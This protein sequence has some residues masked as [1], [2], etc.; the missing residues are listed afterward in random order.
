MSS[1]AF[2]FLDASCEEKQ[3]ELADRL[4]KRLDCAT[5]VSGYERI[6]RHML[7]REHLIDVEIENKV[8]AA[9]NGLKRIHFTGKLQISTYLEIDGKKIENSDRTLP[10][11][12][13]PSL[14]HG[15]EAWRIHIQSDFGGDHIFYLKVAEV[16]SKTS[17]ESSLVIYALAPILECEVIEI[18]TVLDSHRIA[19]PSSRSSQTDY[20]VIGDYVP[21]ERHCLLMQDVNVLFQAGWLVALETDDPVDRGER[22]TPTFIVVQIVKLIPSEDTNSPNLAHVY[23]VR[24]TEDGDETDV[25]ANALYAFRRPESLLEQAVVLHSMNNEQDQPYVHS[26]ASNS[27]DLDAILKELRKTLIEA[28]RLQEDERKRVIRRLR[29]TWH[30]DKN[31]HRKE[32]CTRVFQFLQNLISML[33]AG[34]PIDDVSE[35]QATRFNPERPWRNTDCDDVMRER[36]RAYFR[37]EQAWRDGHRS[38]GRNWSRGRNDDYFEFFREFRQAPNPQPGEAKRWLEQA[39]FDVAASASDVN[40]SNEWVCQKCFQV[41]INAYFRT[42]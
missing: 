29:M 2:E 8:E 34:R 36:A 26:A 33:E 13:E 20:L 14:E 17:L 39:R 30:P 1:V 18:N 21:L 24:I 23:R 31:Q 38:S 3:C 11:F 9:Q 7:K 12:L 19:P 10:Y 40:L 41:T 32:L 37:Q 5:F 35:D 4:R 22:G 42:L 25:R 16:I 27:T 28:W 6:V 15:D